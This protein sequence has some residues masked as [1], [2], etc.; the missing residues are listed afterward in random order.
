MLVDRNGARHWPAGSPDSRGGQWAPSAG[1]AGWVMRVSRRLARPGRGGMV[2]RTVRG[3][4]D[5]RGGHQPP[6]PRGVDTVM[7]LDDLEADMPGVYEHPDWYLSTDT[8]GFREAVRVLRATRGN[9]DA[10]ITIYRGA[11]PGAGKIR[12]GD[13]VTTSR[14]YAE[15]HGRH[16]DDPSQDWPVLSMQVRVRDV[17]WGGN[18]FVE[19]GYWPGTRKP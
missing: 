9:P 14:A 7:R 2:R 16:A 12:R 1:S 17:F 8:P 18:D 19:F 15:A 4:A 5:Y 6:D 3:D 11:P 13:W 10:T